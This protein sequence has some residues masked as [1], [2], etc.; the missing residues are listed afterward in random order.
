MK[1]SWRRSC[2]GS[3]TDG[4]GCS[5]LETGAGDL[6]GVYNESIPL[7]LLLG[8]ACGLATGLGIG[9][10]I[11]DLGSFGVGTSDGSYLC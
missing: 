3:A 1:L 8:S 9:G 2:I 4:D 7:L 5:G 6:F 11:I 10:L